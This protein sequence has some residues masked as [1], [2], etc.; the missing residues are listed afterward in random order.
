MNFSLF[1]PDILVDLNREQLVNDS[2]T[3]LHHYFGLPGNPELTAPRSPEFFLYFLYS[4]ADG[5]H[6]L[7]GPLYCHSIFFVGFIDLLNSAPACKPRGD[8]IGRVY[9][10]FN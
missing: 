10:V 4:L 3:S 1:C 6:V 8:V 2:G 9:D 7:G 5:F